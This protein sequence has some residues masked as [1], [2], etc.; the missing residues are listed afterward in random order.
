MSAA[1]RVLLYHLVDDADGVEAAYHEVSNALADVP[2]L[3]GNEL[4]RSV[5]DARVFLVI[6]TWLDRESFD[7]WEQGTGH[8]ASTAPLRPYR[9]IANPQALGVYQV[10]AAH[11]STTSAV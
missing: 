1:V 8:K 11:Q 3:L 9:D 10:V 2:G 4:L 6:S 5:H 7:R